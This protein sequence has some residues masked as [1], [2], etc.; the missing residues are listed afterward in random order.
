MSRSQQ[1]A[2]AASNQWLQTYYFLRTVVSIVWI[3]LAVFIGR[4]NPT[5][6]V[7]LLVIYPA[8]D[9]LANYIDARQNGG[10]GV[11]PT[12]T[13]NLAVS[14]LTAIAVA[15]VLPKGMPAV[16]TAIGAWAILS[17]VLQLATALRRWKTSGGQWVMVLSGA[18]SALAGAIFFKQA[19]SGMHL[20]VATVAP[21][22]GVGAFYFLVSAIWVTVKNAR[23]R[24]KAFAR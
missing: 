9:A 8:W 5:I 6:G 3:L 1:L 4:S 21:Y 13:L 11:N 24:T 2:N 10:L 22:A 15:V 19:S 23:Q 12:Q 7:A 20:D 18:Q 14:V 16:I 17:G